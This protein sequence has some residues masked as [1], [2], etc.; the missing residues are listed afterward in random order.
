MPED[1]LPPEQIQAWQ[2]MRAEPRV[3]MSFEVQVES[4][5]ESGAPLVERGQVYDVSRHGA[6]VWV[7]RPYEIAE[8]IR[9]IGP[10]KRF[11]APA[12][13][14]NCIREGCHWRIGLQ[15]LSVPE[16]WVIR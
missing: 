10:R 1:D 8:R 3:I 16:E 2:R 15:L 6:A 14:R 7:S 9:L 11:S 5:H 13:V 12:R 4:R